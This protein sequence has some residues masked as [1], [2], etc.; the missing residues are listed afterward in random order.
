LEDIDTEVLDLFPHVGREE[1]VAVEYE[2]TVGMLVGNGFTELLGCPC[3]GRMWGDVDVQHSP[4]LH[5]DDDEDEE[6]L[7]PWGDDG[8]KVGGDDGA[9]VIADERG[10]SLRALLFARTFW[11]LESERS[12]QV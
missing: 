2:E 6:D 7:K 1:K 10:P 9:R 4:R 3:P 8:E 5:F 12:T 11:I